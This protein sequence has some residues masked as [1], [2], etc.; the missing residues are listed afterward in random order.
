MAKKTT[1][2]LSGECMEKLDL[3]VQV[4]LERNRN[5]AIERCIKDFSHPKLNKEIK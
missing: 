4:D 3:I 5:N 2:T 1:F